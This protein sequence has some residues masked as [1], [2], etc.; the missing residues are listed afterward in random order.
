MPGRYE[1]EFRQPAL[2]LLKPLCSPEVSGSRRSSL[3]PNS[4]CP[5]K[6]V[7]RWRRRTGSVPA[8]DPAQQC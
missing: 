6:S 8:G 3:R 2:L 4:V 5:L 7:R 1:P